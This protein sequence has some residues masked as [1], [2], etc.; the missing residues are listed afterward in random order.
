VKAIEV[1]AGI[2]KTIALEALTPIYGSLNVTSGNVNA[3]VFIDGKKEGTTP[4]IINNILIGKHEIK[5]QAEG[6]KPNTQTVNI[7]EGKI[8]ELNATLQEEDKTGSLRIT[9]NTAASVS[10]DGRHVGYTSIT[11]N[12]LLLGEKKVSFESSGYK[13]L[14]KTAT[15]LPGNNNIYG[16]LKNKGGTS[17]VFLSLLIPGLGDHRVTYGKKKGI[18]FA[19]STYALMGTGIG[20]KVYSNREYKKYH[21]ATEQSDMDEYYRKANISHIAF[22]TAIGAGAAV[23]LSD[24][25]F[26]WAKGAENKKT[27]QRSYL[28]FYYHPQLETTI[29]TYTL[30]F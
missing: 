26:V 19:L 3:A 16:E 25:I 21:T 12:N 7:P 9:A 29:L 10:V 13:R 24:I 17:N 11:V 27:Q 28:G 22:C 6:Y 5:L 23:W 14:T 8:F 15:I 18:G 1:T 2:D 30:K 4:A 20:L